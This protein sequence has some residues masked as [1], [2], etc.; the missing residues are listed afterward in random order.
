MSEQTIKKWE[1]L[2]D[3]EVNFSRE[4]WDVIYQLSYGVTDLDTTLDSETLNQMKD[5]VDFKNQIKE[6]KNDLTESVKKSVQFSKNGTVDYYEK[7]G[8]LD[9]PTVE[10][11]RKNFLEGYKQPIELH[12]DTSPMMSSFYKT[13]EAIDFMITQYLK[14]IKRKLKVIGDAYKVLP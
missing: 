11:L 6:R 2:E 12:I 5:D 14:E 9:L 1:T 3:G 13:D 10:R 7:K 4:A 8:T